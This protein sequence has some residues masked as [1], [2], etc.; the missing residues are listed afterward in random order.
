[1]KKI[2]LS[3]YI[4]ILLTFVIVILIGSIFLVLPF[5]SSGKNL[6]YVDALFMSTSSVCVT[7]LSVLKNLSVDLTFFGQ[8]VV[9]ILMIIGGLGFLTFSTFFFVVIGAKLGITN[10]F[11]MREVWNV[12]NAKG[13]IKLVRNIVLFA[14]CFQLFGAIINYFILLS[15]FGPVKSI[16]VSIFH[17]VS[18]FNNVG[19]D[20]FGSSSMI[21]YHNNI[22]LNIS[23]MILIIFGGIGFVSMFDIIKNR[24]WKNLSITTKSIIVITP[25]LIVSGALL[26][27]LCM[28]G[29]ISWLE[30]IFQ[31][32]AS[33]TAGFATIDMSSINTS[34]FVIL[35]VLMFIGGSPCSTAGGIKTTTFFV[36]CI[37]MFKIS[38]GKQPTIFKRK[39]S[40]ITILRSFVILTLS[41][42]FVI[43]STFLVSILDP[44]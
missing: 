7:G 23:T 6:S 1:M 33:R 24:R 18:S 3:P 25:I 32:V 26:I 19:F 36:L 4:K 37:S 29:K 5:S 10:R 14:M 27:K 22:L 13:I 16:W 40:N 11:L 41:I 20:I 2:K 8:F 44:A 34:V 30:A 15:T 9:L 31:S 21:N 17:T 35:I 28:Y 38:I 43:L 42:M 39:I 12:T